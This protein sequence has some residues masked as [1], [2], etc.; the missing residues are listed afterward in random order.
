M[1]L[2]KKP[3]FILG[4]GAQKTGT[5]WL[6]KQLSQCNSVNMGCLKEYHI[7]DANFN[8][9][10]QSFIAHSKKNETSVHRLRRLM[11]NTYGAYEAYF[12]S[13]INQ[14]IRITGDITPS[15]S[16]LNSEQLITIKERLESSG[17]NVKI[18][19]F[20]RDPVMRS[21]SALRMELKEKIQSGLKIDNRALLSEFESF[22]TS[23]L[24]QARTKYKDTVNAIRSSFEK[25][26]IFI[27][28]YENIFQI[29][30]LQALSDFLEINLV[31][32]NIETKINTS[33]SFELTF[34]K[35]MQCHKYYSEVYAYCFDEFPIT[36]EL[37]GNLIV[38]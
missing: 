17:F 38:R 24:C 27:G 1:S 12:L 31:N 33:P 32:A 22:Y 18:V 29:N 3:T 19:Y 26:Q 25:N 35:Y 14:N 34:E 8:P 28:F 15:Y 36:K 11:Q 30:N 4:V 6:H 23:P 20:M 9:L 7:W 37:W 5:T 2:S 10:M 16:M 13:L 21:W